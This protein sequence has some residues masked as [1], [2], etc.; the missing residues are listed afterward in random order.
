MG[1]RFCIFLWIVLLIYNDSFQEEF[2]DTKGLIRIRKSKKDRHHNGK[3][4]KG[5]RTSNDL[6]NKTHKTKDRETR[7]PQSSGMVSSSC[8]TTVTHRVT[9]ATIPVISHEWG[10]DQGVFSTSKA[11]PWSFVLKQLDIRVRSSFFHNVVSSFFIMVN[12]RDISWEWHLH[13]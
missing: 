4:K 8:F 1:F 10:K 6:Q 13:C 9:L 11:Y 7:T 3:T 12:V 5:K 2:K